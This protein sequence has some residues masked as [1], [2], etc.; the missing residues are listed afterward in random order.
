[1][2]TQVAPSTGRGREEK[3]DNLGAQ[4]YKLLDGK[5]NKVSIQMQKGML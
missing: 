3:K 5:G 4:M 1:M 2:R